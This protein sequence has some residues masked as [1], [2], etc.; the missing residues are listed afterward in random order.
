M[1][2]LEFFSLPFL[3]FAMLDFGYVNAFVVPF[4]IGAV[5]SQPKGLVTKSAEG[6]VPA[7]LEASD[8]FIDAFWVGKVGGGA[9]K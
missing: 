5:L 2:Q 1:G 9:T 7:L 3:I 8:F 4:G 6:S